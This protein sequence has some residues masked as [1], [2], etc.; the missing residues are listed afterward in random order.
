M[1]ALHFCMIDKRDATGAKMIQITIDLT[2]IRDKESFHDRIQ[3]AL[4]CPVYY[5]R[6]LDALYDVL[7]D[8]DSMELDFVGY[9]DFAQEMPG[10]SASF[11]DM[12]LEAVAENHDLTILFDGEIP[13]EG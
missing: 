5:G 13:D 10:Y 1:R 12:C 2:D 9:A 6:N 8:S 4:D 7:T 11:K 3:E